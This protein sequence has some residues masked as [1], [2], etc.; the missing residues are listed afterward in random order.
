MCCTKQPEIH[1]ICNAVFY[2]CGK[3][4]NFKWEL[5]C[6]YEQK[7]EFILY[8]EK[9]DNPLVC[10]YVWVY[11]GKFVASLDLNL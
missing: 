8:E 3:N 11:K 7:E 1:T 4:I 10:M 5:I 9:V 6:L 2:M